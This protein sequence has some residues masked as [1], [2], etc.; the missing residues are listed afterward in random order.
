MWKPLL[1]Y[2]G[3]TDRVRLHDLRGSYADIAL[4]RTA[5]IKFIQNQ[6]GHRKSQTTLDIYTQ[7][8]Q[9]MVDKA[10][11]SM[12]D[13]LNGDNNGTDENEM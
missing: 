12:D 7:N 8:S 3:I 9:D 10:L 2:A 4:T 5:N 13:I 1:I 11:G 6:L